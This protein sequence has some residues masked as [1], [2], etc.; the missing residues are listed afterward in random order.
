MSVPHRLQIRPTFSWFLAT[1][2]TYSPDFASPPYEFLIIGEEI[3]AV[4]SAI[5]DYKFYPPFI[6]AINRP[7]FIA[8]DQ[9]GLPIDRGIRT[10]PPGSRSRA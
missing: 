7:G 3:I 9:D 4:K 2:Q 8:G 1:M 5:N 6:A 10:P